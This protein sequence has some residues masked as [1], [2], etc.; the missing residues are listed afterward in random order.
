MVRTVSL[1]FVALSTPHASDPCPFAVDEVFR[2]E[3]LAHGVWAAI[4]QPYPPTYVFANALVVVGERG[5]LVVDTHASTAAAE[6]LICEIERRTDLPVSY[7]VN[8]HWHGDHVQG[9]DAYARAFEGVEI[10][11]HVSTPL[12]VETRTVA[13]VRRE[14]EDLPASIENRRRWLETGRGPDGEALD[15]E[16]R[17]QVA[18]SLRLRSRQLEGLRALELVPPNRTFQDSLTL[19]LGGRQVRLLHA[20]PAH[21]TGDV[22]VWLP[23]DRILAAGD[24]LESTLPYFGEDSDP[25][26]WV[27]ALDRL[28]ALEPEVVL[29]SHGEPNRD[30]RLLETVRAMLGSLVEQVREGIEEG[31]SMEQVQEEI[32]LEAYRAFFTGGDP[33]RDPAFDRG[34]EGAVARAYAARETRATSS[35]GDGGRQPGACA[36]PGFREF[37]FWI[38]EWDIRQRILQ[39]DGTWEE[40]DATTRVEPVLGGCALFERWQ[41]TVQFFWEGMTEPA[42]LEGMSYR[43]Y[44]PEAGEWAIWWMDERNPRIGDPNRGSFEDGIGTFYR[45]GRTGQGNP[46][47]ARIRFF[48]IEEGYF[49]WDLAISTDGRATWSTMWEMEQTRRE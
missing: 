29:P 2:L 26:G 33:T 1:L 47:T 18:Y 40:F 37:D 27:G 39:A 24:V 3:E 43:S 5:V 22:V 8:T 11:G 15:E 44:D 35:P 9:N 19:D 32:D 20:G 25:A 34:V 41:G 49:R 13:A 14:I 31:R 4:A 48:D 21:T 45:D 46:M 36:A 30:G 42:S 28:A 10:V 7:V 12:D 16:D 6:T 23:E 38:G 17:E